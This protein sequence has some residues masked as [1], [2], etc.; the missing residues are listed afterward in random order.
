MTANS[1]L[2]VRIIRTFSSAD[3]AKNSELQRTNARYDSLLIVRIRNTTPSRREVEAREAEGRGHTEVLRTR[4][5]PACYA[6]YSGGD[7]GVVV[8]DKKHSRIKYP[9]WLAN[10]AALPVCRRV[11]V[12]IV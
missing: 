6:D 4:T 9:V 8:I 1:S 11:R 5:S 7:S 12:W 3:H 10:N 2:G